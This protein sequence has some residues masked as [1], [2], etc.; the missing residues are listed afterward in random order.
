MN[1]LNEPPPLSFELLT[2]KRY[3]TDKD[4]DQILST[5]QARP[6]LDRVDFERQLEEAAACSRF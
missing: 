4:I 6:G 2:S 5:F 3:Y 1:E